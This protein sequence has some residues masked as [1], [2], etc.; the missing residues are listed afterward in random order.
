[1]RVGGKEEYA[2][3]D[4]EGAAWETWLSYFEVLCLECLCQKNHTGWLCQFTHHLHASQAVNKH[5][6][7]YMWCLSG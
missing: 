6:C 7:K 3:K 5:V 4:R 2:V 1:M